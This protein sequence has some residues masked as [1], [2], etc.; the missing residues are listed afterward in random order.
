MLRAHVCARTTTAAAAAATRRFTAVGGSRRPA[1]DGGGGGAG[2]VDGRVAG[3]RWLCSCILFCNFYYYFYLKKNRG[4]HRSQ[5]GAGGASDARFCSTR[6]QHGFRTHLRTFLSTQRQVSGTHKGRPQRYRL[7]LTKRSKWTWHTNKKNSTPPACPS[8]P[9]G[10]FHG[11]F[12]HCCKV[13]LPCSSPFF[14]LSPP[15]VVLFFCNTKTNGN[16]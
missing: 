16:R 1:V 7:G 4:T 5:P 11:H 2:V 12:A 14:F 9:R 8:M 15:S 3:G 6:A 10:R 13:V